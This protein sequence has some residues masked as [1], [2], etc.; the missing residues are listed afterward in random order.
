[1]FQGAHLRPPYLVDGVAQ[2]HADVKAIEN[3]QGMPGFS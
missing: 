3:V 2:M 1:V